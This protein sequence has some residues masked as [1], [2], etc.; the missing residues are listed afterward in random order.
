MD[1]DTPNLNFVGFRFSTHA[2]DANWKLVT[3]TDNTH[4]TVTT[5]TGLPAIDTAG[6]TFELT[7]DGTNIRASVDGI[8][9]GSSAG[10]LPSTTQLLSGAVTLDNVSGGVVR[11][12]DFNSNIFELKEQ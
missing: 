9:Y 11:Q 12:L 3:Q 6:H 8:E 4:Q 2:G 7:F 1:T 10:N 5:L